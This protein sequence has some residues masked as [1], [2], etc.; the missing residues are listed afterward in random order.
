MLP[1]AWI[2]LWRMNFKPLKT[3]LYWKGFFSV[4][5]DKAVLPFLIICC[6]GWVDE[7]DMGNISWKETVQTVSLHLVPFISYLK[8]AKV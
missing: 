5:A 6:M 1:A 7:A 8:V 2:Q 4:I 3:P